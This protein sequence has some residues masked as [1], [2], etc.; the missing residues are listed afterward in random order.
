MAGIG[1]Q[2]SERTVEVLEAQIP[3]LAACA[4][5]AAFIRALAAGHAVLKVEG[6]H[7]VEVKGDGSMRVVGETK[8]RRKVST[9]EVVKV[10]RISAQTS[11]V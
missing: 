6:T 8:P 11:F 1:I 10:R 7:I 3:A 9:G 5:H 4:T 2:L